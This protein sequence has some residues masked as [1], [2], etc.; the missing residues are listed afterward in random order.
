[1]QRELHWRDASLNTIQYAMLYWRDAAHN[2]LD[3]LK[4]AYY[5]DTEKILWVAYF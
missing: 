3:A 4:I 5:I 1:M 2:A